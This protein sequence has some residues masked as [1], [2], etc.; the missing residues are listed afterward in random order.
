MYILD[1]AKGR[2]C[3]FF[4]SLG[5]AQKKAL[6]FIWYVKRIDRVTFLSQIKYEKDAESQTYVQTG[7]RLLFIKRFEVPVSA[8][9]KK[10]HLRNVLHHIIDC[11]LN[12][13]SF[14]NRVVA[15]TQKNCLRANTV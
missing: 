13:L 8:C 6:K 11:L 1:S 10:H 5:I 7:G 4:A 12:T 2:T 14:W 15:S 3:S 9:S